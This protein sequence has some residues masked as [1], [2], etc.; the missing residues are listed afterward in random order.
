MDL[1]EVALFSVLGYGGVY[2]H[3]NVLVPYYPKSLV[4]NNSTQV[5]GGDLQTIYSP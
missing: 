4:I 1:G 3:L 5:L 2:T